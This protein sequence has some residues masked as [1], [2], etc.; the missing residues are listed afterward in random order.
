MLVYLKCCWG[1]WLYCLDVGNLL[2][3][4]APNDHFW[5]KYIQNAKHLLGPCLSWEVIGSSW[6]FSFIV[7]EM[8][9]SI[10]RTPQ[11]QHMVLLC[12]AKQTINGGNSLLANWHVSLFDEVSARGNCF[13]LIPTLS[14]SWGSRA[15]HTSD[16][17][18]PIQKADTIR[19]AAM[20][21]CCGPSV[22]RVFWTPT[23]FKCY[24]VRWIY[25]M[26]VCECFSPRL[27]VS[28]KACLFH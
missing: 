26:Y 22:L 17:T 16:C 28:A 24:C 27:S 11:A 21:F 10:W 12:R 20:R 9:A 1:T 4:S 23:G 8:L 14:F 2:L 7:I 6:Y 15:L 5:T 19:N 13:R 25:H 3:W 18:L